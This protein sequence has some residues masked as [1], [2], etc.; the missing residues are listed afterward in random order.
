[1]RTVVKKRLQFLAVALAVFGSGFQWMPETVDLNGG[2]LELAPLLLGI[3]GYFVLLPV[4]YWRWI[5]KAGE[6]KAWKIIIT[7]SLSCLCARYSFPTNFAEYF[8][9]I[10]YVRYPIIAVVLII[11]LFLLWTIIKGL[12]S[13]RSLSGDPR[14]HTFE[15]Y[16][17][18]DKKLTAALPMSWEP[19]SWYYAIPRFSRKHVPAVANLVVNS[20]LTIHYCALMFAFIAGG[21]VSYMLL[22]GW[23]EIAAIIVSSLCFYSVFFVT[24]NHRIAKRYSVYFHE[25]KLMINNAFWSF[26]V[27][28]ITDIAEVNLGQFNK[29]DNK[30]QLMLG[31]GDLANIE[32]VFSSPQTYI[33]TLGQLN[34]SVDRIWLN[35]DCPEHLKASLVAM[36]TESQVA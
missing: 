30:E 13:A 22:V 12:W 23:S 29:K 1:M 28:N 11:E 20:R 15:K 34:E 3:F 36:T 4:L 32:L 19:S 35:L 16:K 2:L 27:V 24:A 33:A 17:D 31:K 18:D 25:D 21:A 7:L 5:I 9:F 10:T 6:Q 14:I 26:I 8:D